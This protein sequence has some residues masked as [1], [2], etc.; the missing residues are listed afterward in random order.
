MRYARRNACLPVGMGAQNDRVLYSHLFT[1]SIFSR[2]SRVRGAL[3]G[4]QPPNYC[5]IFLVLYC[6]PVHLLYFFAAQRRS[7]GVWRFSSD[8]LGRAS[9]PVPACHGGQTVP[10]L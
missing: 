3:A 9:V 8:P 2:R 4:P 5:I 6:S 1:C 7:G 10:G